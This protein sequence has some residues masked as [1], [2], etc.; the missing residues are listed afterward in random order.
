[1]GFGYLSALLIAV[2][3]LLALHRFLADRA[4]WRRVRRAL[5]QAGAAGELRVLSGGRGKRI[6]PGQNIPIPYEG[7]LGAAMSCDVCIPYRK[8]HMRSAFF[9]IENGELHM[10]PLHRDGFTVDDVDVEPGDEAVML[11]GAVLCV[12]E[13]KMVLR[14]YKHSGVKAVEIVDEP[15]VTRARRGRAQQGRGDGIGAPGRGQIRREK[16]QWKKQLNEAEVSEAR[17]AAARK[18]KTR[19]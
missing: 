2:I 4:L 8:V 3:V 15:Y 19:R 13:L 1:M 17:E 11:D 12:G 18:R 14:L 16:K 9:W 7:T 5:P 10:V 6:A